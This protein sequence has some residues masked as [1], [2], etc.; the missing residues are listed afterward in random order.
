ML[1]EV[2]EGSRLTPPPCLV[3][4]VSSPKNSALVQFS[5]NSAQERLHRGLIL[6][7]PL[8]TALAAQRAMAPQ[9]QAL[10]LST[11]GDA[12]VALVPVLRQNSL[13]SDQPLQ[14]VAPVR[15][16][17]RTGTRLP[18]P[19]SS[20]TLPLTSDDERPTR[21]EGLPGVASNWGWGATG[22]ATLQL[23][24]P[25][26]GRRRL[27]KQVIALPTGPPIPFTEYLQR[28]DDDKLHVLVAATGLVATIKVPLIVDKLFKIY[29]NRVL[30]QVVATQLAL[31]FLNGLK[32]PADVRVW[33]DL[34]EWMAPSEPGAQKK[35]ADPVLHTELRRWADIMLLA[36]LSANTLAKMANG[37]C[38]NLLTSIIR[39]WN[40]STPMLVAP[41]MNTFMY[42]HPLTKRHLQQIQEDCPAIT[43]LKPVEKVLVCGDIGMGG[44]R[45]WNDVVEC[46]RR[47][48][49]EMRKSSESQIDEEEEEEEEGG[50]NDTDTSE[51]L[52][53]AS[54][55]TDTSFADAQEPEEGTAQPPTVTLLLD[56]V[57]IR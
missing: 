6:A 21:R 30:V 22:P 19:G 17:S 10:L 11:R 52:D 51:D 31:Y 46:L 14:F 12:G 33:R 26:V 43:V 47:K 41:A 3:N 18:A 4:S 57:A 2:P 9:R 40:P 23:P 38:D 44:M 34:D 50:E 20:V 5:S 28:E 35:Q 15:P 36:P 8:L 27:V 37:I 16:A 54:E 13:Q 1:H 7:V 53:D 24:A 55:V 48:V 32:I 29:G 45:E 42:T 25:G 39:Q 49:A 56:Q